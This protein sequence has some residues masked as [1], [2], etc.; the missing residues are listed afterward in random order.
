MS[1]A[2]PICLAAC[3]SAVAIP[4]LRAIG[5]DLLVATGGFL[6]WAGLARYAP[7]SFSLRYI[8]IMG[9]FFTTYSAM[10]VI[11]SLYIR[12]QLPEIGG[13][14]FYYGVVGVL[15]LSGLGWFLVH[16]G[17]GQRRDE[18]EHYF[19]APITVERGGLAVGMFAA[20]CVLCLALAA[21]HVVGAPVNPLRMLLS[22]ASSA[23]LV[24]AR[25]ASLKTLPG[26]GSSTW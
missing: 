14:W 20:L 8:S 1:W 25:E 15:P 24:A 11:P 4:G 6:C 23:E 17:F 13:P 9:V 7:A 16:R 26:A 2:L 21:L 18:F 3:L 5:P 19:Q 10:I 12:L 22:S